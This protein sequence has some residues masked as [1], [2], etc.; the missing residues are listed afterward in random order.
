MRQMPGEVTALVAEVV[1]GEVAA[2]V[3]AMLVQLEAHTPH[4]L[5]LESWVNSMVILVH[6]LESW[7]NS[8]VILVKSRVHGLVNMTPACMK[9]HSRLGLRLSLGLEIWVCDLVRDI[10]P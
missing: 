9:A 7:V 2:L 6:S 8:M 1:Q 5:R 4:A 10:P 3:G